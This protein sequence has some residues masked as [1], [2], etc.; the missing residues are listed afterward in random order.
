MGKRGP[1]PKPTALRVFEGDPGRLLGKREGEPLPGNS[2]SLPAPPAW[3]GDVGKAEW[4]KAAPTLHRMGCLT[5]ADE[6]L[7][8][9]YCEAWDDFFAAR[10]VL[11]TEGRVVVTNKGMP[12]SHP[13]V[14][15]KK[16]AIAIIKQ[17][18][19]EFGMSP[20]A[21]VGLKVGSTE[22]INALQ[23]FKKNG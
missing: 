9:L 22:K 13:A 19:A 12:L 23:A 2:E 1:K 20:A 3:L 4:M 8:S 5:L 11:E 21:R 14:K 16:D 17:I 7:L 10:V 18:G 15:Q 6:K